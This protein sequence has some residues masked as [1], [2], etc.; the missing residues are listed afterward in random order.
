M[1]NNTI[2]FRLFLDK[3][4]NGIPQPGGTFS[5]QNSND[6][7]VNIPLYVNY[8][9]FDDYINIEK[10]KNTSIIQRGNFNPFFIELGFFSEIKATSTTG[11]TSTNS[12]LKTETIYDKSKLYNITINK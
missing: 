4:K 12:Y 7:F 6:F 10:D 2:K 9:K 1:E 3:R 11:Q 5:E 8:S